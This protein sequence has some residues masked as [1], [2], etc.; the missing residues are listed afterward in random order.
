[1]VLS[2]LETFKS[3]TGGPVPVRNRVGGGVDGTRPEKRD[4]RNRKK[5]L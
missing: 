2:W 4:M 1:M 5:K 3:K